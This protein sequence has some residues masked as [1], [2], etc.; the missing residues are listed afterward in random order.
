MTP[1]PRCSPSDVTSD[2][3][4]S[5]DSKPDLN[6]VELWTIHVR[7]DDDRQRILA[8][9]GKDVTFTSL[10]RAKAYCKVRW[11]KA[12]RVQSS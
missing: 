3:I 4:I 12:Q 11:P 7:G 1:I 5:F 9:A 8:D 6:G 10:R 2:S